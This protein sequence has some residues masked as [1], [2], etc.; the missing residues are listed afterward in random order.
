VVRNFEEYKYSEYDLRILYNICRQSRW[1]PKHINQNKLLNGIAK[2]KLGEAKDALKSL[3]RIG[4]LRKYHAEGRDDYC[5]PKRNR[6]AVIFILKK[7][8]Q[9]YRFIQYIDF[10]K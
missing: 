7:Y 6:F 8:E 5:I 4:L 10:I 3:S 2:D 9:E 1:C